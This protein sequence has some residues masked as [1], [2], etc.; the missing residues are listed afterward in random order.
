VGLPVAVRRVVAQADATRT[1]PVAAQKI[2]RDARFIDEDV[3]ARV[4]QRLGVLPAA[5]IGSDVRPALLVGVY[6]FF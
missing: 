3:G 4:V 5:A 1:S 6:R 2:C